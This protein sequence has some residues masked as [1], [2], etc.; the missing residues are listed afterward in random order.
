[1]PLLDIASK[2]ICV[3]TIFFM[4]KVDRNGHYLCTCTYEYGA[5]LV[6]GLLKSRG[7]FLSS[8]SES[9]QFNDCGSKL[10]T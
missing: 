2:H 9:S 7:F 3:M 5:S 10:A 6:T 8:N 1:M 4:E